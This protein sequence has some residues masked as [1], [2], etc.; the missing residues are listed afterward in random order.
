MPKKEYHSGI[1]RDTDD[2]ER[3]GRLLIECP[4]VA[5]GQTMSWAEPKFHFVDSAQEA[6]SFWVP[7]VDSIVEVEIEAEEDSEVNSLE[8]KWRCDVYPAGTVPEVFI[9]NYPER[10]GWVTAAGHVLYF[11]DTDGERTLYYEHPSGTKIRVVENGNIELTPA[12]GQS[13]LIGDGADQQLVKGNNLF[14]WI[15]S[16]LKTWANAH[17]HSGVMPGAG[18]SGIVDPS[19]FLNGPTSTYILSDYHKVK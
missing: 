12:A 5:Y 6:G 4:D 18:V 10:R 13:V 1:V 3:R 8:P 2:P 16:V 19:S 17:K 15:D 11:D 9:E 7:N 14:S